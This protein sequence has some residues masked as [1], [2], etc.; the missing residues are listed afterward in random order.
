LREL[1]AAHLTGGQGSGLAQGARGLTLRMLTRARAHPLLSG[2][3]RAIPQ[4]WQ[5]RVKNWLL[6]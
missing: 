2:V 3:A 6:E 4:H 1:I 5:R